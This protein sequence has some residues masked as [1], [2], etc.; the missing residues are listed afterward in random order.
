MTGVGA[1]I[2][3]FMGI[4]ARHS[5]KPQDAVNLVQSALRHERELTPAVAGSLYGQLASSA[6]R[7][8][9]KTTSERAQHRAFELLSRSDPAAEPDY[10]Y[11]FNESEVESRAGSANLK[12]GRP[13]QAE[14]HFRRALAHPGS[15]FSRD[16][17]HCLCES[18]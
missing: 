13:T 10:I 5:A 8:G 16:R 11:W 4:Q 18:R 17:A 6:A 3:G 14:A 15:S 1:N 7:V 12:L 9:D 2:L